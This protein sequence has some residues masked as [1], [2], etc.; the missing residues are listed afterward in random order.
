MKNLQSAI[1]TIDQHIAKQKNGLGEDLFFLVSRCTPMVNVDLLIKNDEGQLLLTWRD[2]QFY[3]PGWHIPGGI[4]RHKETF[5][6]RIHQVAE[7]ELSTNVQHD[8]SPSMVQEL[9]NHERDTR[10][11]FISLLYN[12]TL[13][14]NLSPE[15]AFNTDNPQN[16]QWQWHST[17]PTNL[18]AVH[19]KL[20][21]TLFT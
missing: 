13:L 6:Q 4:I 12:C 10:G 21:S 15:N 9:M 3:G 7:K 20:Y 17:M 19:K 14:K 5:S 18:I 11:H 1:Q 8:E 16:N 2:D